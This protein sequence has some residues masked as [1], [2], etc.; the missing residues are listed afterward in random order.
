MFFKPKS[1]P[2]FVDEN[3]LAVQF[4]VEHHEGG[5]YTLPVLI[6]TAEHGYTFATKDKDTDL[7]V[8]HIV[9]NLNK[10]VQ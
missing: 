8:S 7:Q 10:D 1:K 5:Y 6:E 4:D 3:T 9:P 2:L